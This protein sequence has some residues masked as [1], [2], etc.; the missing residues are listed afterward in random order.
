MIRIN[1]LG[2]PR[3]K[4]GKR[5]AVGAG[6]GINPL[7]VA[8]VVAVL[9]LGINF[10]WYWKLSSEA[11]T[12]ATENQKADQERARL[13]EVKLR[14]EEA[15]RTR[16]HYRVRYEV[17]DRLRSAQSGPVDLLTMIGDTVNK[18]DA[19]WLNTMKE[20]GNL[21]NIEGVALSVHAVANLITN[22]KNTGYFENVEIKES[23]QDERVT[24][25][26]AFQF[27]LS[28]EKRRTTT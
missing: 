20:E 23:Y 5:A 18:T 27:T 15:E 11:A 9:T 22:L 21:V 28:C 16:E 1:L 13:N 17:I 25:M 19:V 14:F 4:K 24:D 12:L 10:G 7:L 6:E 8:A 26:T 2:G 3:P